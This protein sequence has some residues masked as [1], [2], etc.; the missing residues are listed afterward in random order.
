MIIKIR[1]MKSDDKAPVMKLLNSI[2][3]FMTSEVTV[4]EEVIDTYLAGAGDYIISVAEIS[5]NLVGYI[6]YGR[7]P[8]TE[9]TWDVYWMAV[10][11]DKQNQGVGRLLLASA[12]EEISKAR[13]RLIIIE[14]SS[15]PEYENTRQFHLHRGYRESCRISDFYAP[16]DSKNIYIKE[17]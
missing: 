1:R 9:S 3:E 2:P 12:E 10:L 5:S 4:A 16:G 11:P 8:I 14:T 6:C 17:I 7:T 13:G 15:K